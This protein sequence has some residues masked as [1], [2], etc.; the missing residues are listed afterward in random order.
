MNSIYMYKNKING[1]MYIGLASNP[2]RRY[3]EHKNVA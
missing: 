3:N 1:H 2:Q